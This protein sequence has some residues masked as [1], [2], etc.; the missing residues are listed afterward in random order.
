MSSD[1]SV[2]EPHLYME[3]DKPSPTSKQPVNKLLMSGG[4]RSK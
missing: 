2:I 4:A 3:T 1:E